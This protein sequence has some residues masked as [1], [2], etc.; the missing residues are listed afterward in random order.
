MKRIV[1]VA[2]AAASFSAPA[3]AQDSSP[4]TGFRVEALGGYDSLTL[5]GAPNPDGLL[6][7]VGVGYDFQT[8][9]RVLGLE[10]DITDS[11]A[12]LKD[13]TGATVAVTDRDIYVGGRIGTTIGNSALLYA[14]AGYT[15]ARV[16]T[17][18]GNANADGIR[19]GAGL[20]Y[21]LGQNLFVKA[22][23]RYSNY[24]AGV[25]RNQVVGGFGFR[26]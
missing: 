18:V 7:G 25:E 6:Y 10:A 11:D 21:A 1:A 9:G 15:N 17:V 20:E 23:Y 4:F 26:F 8:A 2:L 22:E 3:F 14:K 5:P 13:G 16:E 19:A 12:K 24:E